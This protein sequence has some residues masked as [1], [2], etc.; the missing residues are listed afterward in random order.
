VAVEAGV[1]QGWE[2]WLGDQGIF[3]GLDRFGASAPY[4][5]V[6]RHLGL[7]ADHVVRVVHGLVGEKEHG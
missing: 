1:G 5:D 6:Y 4:K 3:V 7:T 2:R